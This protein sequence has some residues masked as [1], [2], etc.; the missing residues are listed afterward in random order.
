MVLE[1]KIN[2]ESTESHCILKFSR[3][4]AVCLLGLESWGD[5]VNEMSSKDKDVRHQVASEGRPRPAPACVDPIHRRKPKPQAKSGRG[6][7]S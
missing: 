2:G 4:T 7:G 5:I 6:V 1:K 3:T